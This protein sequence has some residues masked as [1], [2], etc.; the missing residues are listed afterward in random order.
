MK[1]N[2]LKILF[3]M[4]I[5]L[6]SLAL[7]YVTA[8]YLSTN[9]IFDYWG[10]IAIFA[11]VYVFTSVVFPEPF[12]PMSAYTSPSFKVRSIFLTAAASPN[13]FVSPCMVTIS[14][15]L[16][17]EGDVRRGIDTTHAIMR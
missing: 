3:G 14:I 15:F 5:F 6:F 12:G 4:V 10:T 11:G 17:T 9:G 16:F 13:F 1:N 8:N 7:G 2:T